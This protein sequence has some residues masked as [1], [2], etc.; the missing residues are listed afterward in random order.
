MCTRISINQRRRETREKQAS[1]MDEYQDPGIRR[2]LRREAQRR[3]ARQ[4]MRVSTRPDLVRPVTAARAR[5]LL[6]RAPKRTRKR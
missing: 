6:A 3:R 2:S 5:K 4:G 1:I